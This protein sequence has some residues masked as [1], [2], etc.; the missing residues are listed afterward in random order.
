MK[1]VFYLVVAVVLLPLLTMAQAPSDTFFQKYNEKQGI[2]V[3]AISGFML[4]PFIDNLT[5]QLKQDE[6]DEINKYIDNISSVAIATT[7][8]KD[9]P[10]NKDLLDEA[11]KLSK[12][13]KYVAQFSQKRDDIVFTVFTHKN[14]NLITE[15]LGYGH[16]QHGEAMVVSVQGKFTEKMIKDALAKAM[17]SVTK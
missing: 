9:L 12:N 13:G 15:I 4:K 11:G 16:N 14:N 1:R 3:M 2:E 7:T 8:Q 6:K 10:V 5:T 17:A